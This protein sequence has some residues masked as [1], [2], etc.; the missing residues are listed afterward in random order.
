PSQMTESRPAR[1]SSAFPASTCAGAEMTAVLCT[2]ST[3]WRPADTATTADPAR[4]VGRVSGPFTPAAGAQRTAP[5]MVTIQRHRAQL[6]GHAK[7]APHVGLAHPGRVVEEAGTAEHGGVGVRDAEMTI[8][9]GGAVG[10]AVAYVLS[11]AGYADI[12]VVE[13]GELA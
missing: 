9:G 5:Y 11:R 2:H 12:Q 10:C 4:K 7:R 3:G 8:V 6:A 1:T 13:Q